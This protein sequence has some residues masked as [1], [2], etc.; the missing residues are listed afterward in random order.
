MLVVPCG[1]ATAQ[2]LGAPTGAL[3]A[4]VPYDWSNPVADDAGRTVPAIPLGFAFPMA[5]ALQLGPNPGFATHMFVQADGDIYLT[6]AYY[7]LARPIYPAW[8]GLE[9][10]L[11]VGT[12]GASPRIGFSGDFRAAGSGGWGVYV[13]SSVSGEI[14]VHWHNVEFTYVAG[15]F[16]FAITLEATGRI[17][18][19]VGPGVP[20][21]YLLC[22]VSI[23][24]GVFSYSPPVSDLS[25]GADSGTLGLLYEDYTTTPDIA[26]REVVFTPNGLGGFRSSVVC[27]PATH[28]AYGSGCYDIAGRS[29]YEDFWAGTAAFDLAGSSLTM[30]FLGTGYSVASGTTSFVPPSS[31][32]AV[33]P[34]TDNSQVPVSL[35]QAFSYPGGVTT[36]LYVC[37]NGF[38]SSGAGNAPAGDANPVDMLNSPDDA[39]RC[40]WHDYDPTVGNVK[41]E[42]MGGVAYVTWD[43]VRSNYYGL[44]HTFQI[45]FNLT[46]GSVHYVWVGMPGADVEYMVGYAPGS[47]TLIDGG[48]ID[49]SVA[50]PF[51]LLGT[52]IP[53]LSLSAAPPPLIT[54]G[55]SGPSVPITWTLANVPDAVPPLGIGLSVLFFSPAPLVSG[56]DLGLL[57]IAGCSLHLQSLDVMVPCTSTTPTA[58]VTLA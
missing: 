43:A 4:L 9:P 21:A 38:V 24:D 44:P 53:S 17:R 29:F 48:S 19:R 49:L 8:A 46:T 34:L 58:A 18:M 13:D 31:G 42:E 22:G 16:S 7:G 32:A 30:A 15:S 50:V 10:G 51:D 55:G 39:W 1:T 23:G 11:M 3:Q 52:D 35:S 47:A 56:I 45:Q 41:F 28:E 26:G 20:D 36:T 12:V 6:N 2:C 14:T 33:L 57:G 27:S 25:L 37:D 5:G 54:A 40:A